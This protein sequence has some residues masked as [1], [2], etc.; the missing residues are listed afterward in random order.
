[1]PVRILLVLFSLVLSLLSACA[2]R[3]QTGTVVGAGAGA[4]IGEQVGEGTAGTLV[5]AIAGG[6]LGRQI[7]QWMDERDRQEVA[8]TLE[9]QPSGETT[10]WVNPDTGREFRVTPTETWVDAER[11]RPCR[12]FSMDIDGEVENV[13][14]TACR[15]ADG[16]WEIM[17]SERD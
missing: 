17:E 5:G 6:L 10:A 8:Q 3:E 12:R 15:V 14:G 9:Y 2:T 13:D 4:V 11:D 1:M 16:R 7:G